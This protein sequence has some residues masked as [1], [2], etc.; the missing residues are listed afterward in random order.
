MA[1]SGTTTFN[2]NRSEIIYAALRKLHVIPQ[3]QNAT[4]DQL[5]EANEELNRL[6]KSLQTQGV[7][8]WT[9]DWITQVP[10]AASEVTG[11]DGK[12]YTCR[13]SHTSSTD[14]TPITG[15]DYSD[16]W[17]V[18]GSTGGSWADTTAYTSSC[19]FSLGSDYIG[20]EKAFVRHQEHDYPI[21]IISYYDYL[22]KDDKHIRVTIPEALSIDMAEPTKT[23]YIYPYPEDRTAITIHMLAIKK[24]E[25]FTADA[26]N[27]DFPVRWLNVLVWGLAAYLAPEY[28]LES[29]ADYY[30]AMY[31]DE[32][33]NAKKN[34]NEIRASF[35]KSPFYDCRGTY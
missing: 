26:N 8:L 4:A 12:I 2:Q 30:M 19:D 23:V 20:I 13:K 16:Y 25:D 7:R 21:D 24:L 34:D 10:Q 15:A 11:T 33:N 22:N 28:N 1:T 32:L 27:P 9:R 5:T 6:V 35:I 3:G 17:Y 29:K 18:N 31:K 14:D